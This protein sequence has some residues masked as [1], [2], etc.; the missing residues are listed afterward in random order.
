MQIKKIIAREGLIFIGSVLL[1]AVVY[2]IARHFNNVYLLQHQE[3]K[4]KVVQ[5]LRYSLVGYTPY[6]NMM[7]LGVNI[8]FWGYPVLAVGRFILWAVRILREK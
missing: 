7:S 6:M 3:E 4:V 5:S 8:A 2:F 1:G